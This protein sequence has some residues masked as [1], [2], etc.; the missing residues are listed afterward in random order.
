M[1]ISISS[2]IREKQTTE[3]VCGDVSVFL[4][5]EMVREKE[6]GMYLHNILPT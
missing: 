2:D 5:L 4:Y 3:N 1:G 6:E